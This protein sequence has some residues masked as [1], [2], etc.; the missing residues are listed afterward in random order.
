VIRSHDGNSNETLQ[1]AEDK[2]REQIEALL[3]K[4]N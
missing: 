1:A 3:P 2:A 4:V